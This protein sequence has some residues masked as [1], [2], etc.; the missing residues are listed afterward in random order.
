MDK[1]ELVAAVKAELGEKFTTKDTE[2]AVNAVFNTVHDALVKDGE[3][4]LVGFGS[5]KVKDVPARQGHNPKT[6]E[7]ITIPD[8]KAVKFKAG[9]ALA[10]DVNK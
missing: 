9:K 5:F 6:G 1:K 4:I 8:H 3:V 2:K 10:D 7:T